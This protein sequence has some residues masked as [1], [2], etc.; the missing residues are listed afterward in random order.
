[1]KN[2]IYLI[3]GKSE[4]ISSY[5]IELQARA[6]ADA[7]FLTY[8]KPL[9]IAIFF[10][11]STW[12]QGRNKLLSEAL[13]TAKD[14]LYYIFLDDDI[15]FETG[16]WDFFEKQLLKYHPAIAITTDKTIKPYSVVWL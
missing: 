3:Q 7:I 4:L 10:P 11:N 8:D 2:F 16:N 12:A 5:F 15:T 9:E 14:Y 6:D 13:K 1:M